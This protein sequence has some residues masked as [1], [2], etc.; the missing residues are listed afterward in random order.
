LE[1]RKSTFIGLAVFATLLLLTQLL[2][3]QQYLI[4]RQSEKEKVLREANAISDKLKTS[5][6]YSLSATKTLAF[7][8][9]RYGVP[10]D[11]D[12]IAQTILESNQF[13]DAVELTQKGVITH[14]YPLENNEEAVGL[15]VLTD[16]ITREEARKA[17]VKR[18]L[19]FAGPFEL[20]QGGMGVVGRLP[21][22]KGKEFVGFS[23]VVIRLST[24]L[25]A[26][27]IDSTHPTYAYQL[28]KINAVT[29]KE[30]FFLEG[31]AP[32]KGE[33]V[34]VEV[35]DGEWNLYVLLKDQ[36]GLLS[37]VMPFSFLGLLLSVTAGLFSWHFARQPEKLKKR[38]EEVTAEMNAYQRSATE[39][40]ERVNRLYHFTSRINHLVVHVTNEEAMYR[41]VCDIAV[42]IGQFSMAWIG[43]INEND[44]KIYAVS[45]AGDL[46][47]YL[48]E[49]APIPLSPG[50]P[51]GPILRIIRTGNLVHCNDIATDPLMK[52]WAEKALAR[53]YRSSVL[54]PIRKMGKIVGSFNLYATVANYFDNAE[55]KLLLETTDN[56]SFTLDN[57]EKD[58]LR[59]VAEHQIQSEKM[60]SDSIIN[61][62]PGVFY[63]YDRNGRFLRWNKNFEDITGYNSEEMKKIHPLNF[64]EG[65]EQILLKE[66]I[67]SVFE[68]GYDH[69]IA[70]FV[71]KDKR[72]IPYYFNGRKVNFNGVDY[73]IG[74]GLD[75]TD[76]V[77]VERALRERTEEIEKLSAHLQ[78]IRE[79][80]RSHIALEIHDV[81]GQQLTALKMDA[82]WLKRKAVEDHSVSERIATMIAL[83]D[84]TIKIV[85]R[86]S[87]ELRPGILDDLGLV[88]ALEWQGAEFQKN[89]GV[90]VKFTSNKSDVQ[91]ERNFSTNVFRVYQEALTN[92]ARHANATLVHTTFTCADEQIK[93]EIRDDGQGIDYNEAKKKKSLGL[94]S[95][96]ERARLFRGQVTVENNVPNGTI[97]T[98]TI[99]IVKK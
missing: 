91:L 1:S 69:V 48:A 37:H 52:P 73:L 20:R 23:V 61:S 10:Q 90:V 60:L 6:S 42:N 44:Q 57:F 9:G 22:F 56:I 54:L 39:S 40:L 15:D 65:D 8:V 95:M 93:L 43:I 5:L 34:S 85:R 80:E 63:L 47:G 99:P 13:I 49:I 78:N 84:D 17:L 81:L 50:Q 71:T 19:F 62:L 55:I 21:I 27:G 33:Y 18:A 94:I 92:I 58:R 72:K 30:E 66:K 3:Y 4:Y 26:A 82:T 16:S 25:R 35:P 89:T 88:A 59:S 31:S 74:M 76:R 11:F 41:K 45:S 36:S 53:G 96:K 77:N 87:S 75:I 32:A 14:V 51:E 12:S 68:T 64:F 28:S 24:L 2:T 70:D 7:L 79:E 98:M 86:I 46:D 97:V 29:G 83:I 67:E 38:V